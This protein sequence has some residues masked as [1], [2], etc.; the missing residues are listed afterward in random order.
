MTTSKTVKGLVAAIATALLVAGC[1]TTSDT[2]SPRGHC[3]DHV[4]D[5]I[6]TRRA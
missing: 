5:P 4:R 3:S 6:W 1:A 2:E